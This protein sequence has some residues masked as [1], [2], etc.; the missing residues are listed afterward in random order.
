[1][2]QKRRNVLM[3]VAGLIALLGLILLIVGIV[4]LTKAK[5]EECGA[6]V[7]A[8]QDGGE[9]SDRC[10]YS[11][12]AK[13]A[14][15]D[16]FL[17]KVQDTYYDLHPQ[18]LIYKPGGIERSVLMEK[19]KPYNPE[20]NNLKRITDSALR[21]LDELQGLGVNTRRLKP[22]EKKAIAQVKHY[23]ENSF[24]A[25]YD[26]DYYAGDFLMGPNLFCWQPICNIGYSDIAQGLGNF[27]LK[28]LDDVR[29]FLNKIK[30]VEG[31]FSTY[32]ENMRLGIKAGM[33]RSNEECLAGIDAFKQKYLQ[34]SI[35]GEQGM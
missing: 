14:G 1:M 33:V 12:E 15:V 28:D 32:I 16:K 23:L 17:Q 8:G 19:F 31:T 2:L 29:L 6:A 22:R 5:N 3:L 24:G 21:L 35:Q 10:S 30:L 27:H 26:A 4:Q 18:D 20:P 34:V 11:E 9:K 13:R 7:V 25:P